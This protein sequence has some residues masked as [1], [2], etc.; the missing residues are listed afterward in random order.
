MRLQC[1]HSNV[2][3]LVN[4]N[5]KATVEDMSNIKDTAKERKL[6]K[7]SELF[8]TSLEANNGSGVNGSNLNSGNNTTTIDSTAYDSVAKVSNVKDMEEERRLSKPRFSWHDPRPS[9]E[10]KSGSGG[11]GEKTDMV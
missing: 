4:E 10:D 6:N 8:C 2:S 9:P 1:D 11:G 5:T 3:T 7:E